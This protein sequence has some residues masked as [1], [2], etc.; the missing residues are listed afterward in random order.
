[1]ATITTIPSKPGALE[2]LRGDL[3]E[4]EQLAETRRQDLEQ[5][6]R[7]EDQR[8]RQCHAEQRQDA[9][10]DRVAARHVLDEMKKVRQ[11]VQGQLR[12][13]QAHAFHSTDG[14]ALLRAG[15]RSVAAQQH[16]EQWEAQA[17]ITERQM[18]ES[19]EQDK[20]V[21]K[22]IQHAA[23]R[24]VAAMEDVAQKRVG[25]SHELLQFS[26]DQDVILKMH[27]EEQ[28]QT[29]VRQAARVSKVKVDGVTRA[30]DQA[31]SHM[32][33]A[34]SK[35]KREQH[36]MTRD[37]ERC[38]EAGAARIFG[39]ERQLKL[40]EEEMKAALWREE[41]CATQIKR[42][43][44]EWKQTVQEEFRERKQEL[45]RNLERVANYEHKKKDPHIDAQ[46]AMQVKTE[47]VSHRGTC[48]ALDARTRAGAE[49]EDL[50]RRLVI[51]KEQLAK[52]EVKCA[53]VVKELTN[54]W[55]DA[56]VVYSQRVMEVESET[57]DLLRRLTAHREMH[58]EFCAL[59]LRKTKEVQEERQA[60]VRNQGALS[61]ELVKQRA[62]FCQQKSAQT[63]RQAEARLEEAKRRVEDVDRRCQERVLMGKDT[64][65]EKVRIAQER[66]A[67]QVDVAERRAHEAMDSR[68]KASM[69]FHAALSRCSGAAD[70]AR[71]RGLFEVAEML[72][73]RDAWCGFNTLR[74]NT[75]EDST[76]PVTTASG[77]EVWTLKETS[78]TVFPDRG[79]TPMEEEAR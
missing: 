47:E 32:Q 18:K 65:E 4:A 74:P 54:R 73:P 50:E 42:V 30:A 48:V 57:E 55:E 6:K 1:M 8:L 52:L 49:V 71:R 53:S 27:Q 45:D 28:S 3:H 22:I 69:A 51:A 7:L 66:L 19:I 31:K 15:K 36:R 21:L 60:V 14:H 9:Q 11:K 76:R 40:E 39:A 25:K 75:A 63:R 20:E 70:E 33:L 13:A 78:S 64:A 68:D 44:G 24:R 59:S 77:V 37:V 61:Q 17:K 10:D 34:E 29:Q 67:E 72:M 38:V 58:E 5:A 35:A 12:A 79:G 16:Q 56:K 46:L 23:D 43:A 62:A 2:A 41:I 26:K